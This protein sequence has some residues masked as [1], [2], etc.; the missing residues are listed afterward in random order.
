M[1]NSVYS[2]VYRLYYAQPV[3]PQGRAAGG[4]QLAPARHLDGQPHDDQ[5]APQTP[6]TQQ[7][8]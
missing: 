1:R 8:F 6:Q 5:K 3:C 4:D 7:W 2:L